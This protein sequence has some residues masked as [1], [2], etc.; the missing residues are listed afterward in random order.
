MRFGLVGCG[1][2]GRKRAA[3]L[4]AL[5]GGHRLTAL[6]D[7]DPSRASALAA[8]GDAEVLSGWQD[9]VESPQVDALLVATPHDLL[10]PVTKAALRAGKHV[11]V[12]KPA[13]RSLE[14]A[15]ELRRVHAGGSA[16][17]RVGFNHRYH[18]ALR[19]AAELSREGAIGPLLLVRGRYGHG[20]RIGYERE[21]RA[22]RERAG[23]GELV[24]QGMHLID[25]CRGLLGDLRFEGGLTRGLFWPMPVEDNAFLWLGG[26]AGEVASLHVSWTEWKNLFSLEIFGRTGKLEVDGLGGSYGLERLTLHRMG[27]EMGPPVTESWTFPGAD[28]SFA[29]ELAEFAAAVE[30]RPGIGATIDD[31]VAAWRIVD[32]AYR[33]APR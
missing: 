5:G 10:V 24:D 6:C 11:L 13:G 7:A 25:L 31:A 22:N 21:W 16:T 18:P 26:P 28:L 27:P 19:R 8:A 29:E 23:G 33:E 15:E 12:E 14:E 2:V 32:R 9:V 30:G 1:G 3:A 17:L 20:G 4:A